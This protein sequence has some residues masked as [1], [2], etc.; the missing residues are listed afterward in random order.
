[1]RFSTNAGALVSQNQQEKEQDAQEQEQ[2][3]DRVHNE[4]ENHIWFV[5]TLYIPV[6]DRNNNKASC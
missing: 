6:V 5:A 4:E 1:V 2:G 3:I